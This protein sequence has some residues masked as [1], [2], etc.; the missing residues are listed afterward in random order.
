MEWSVCAYGPKFPLSD[1]EP[2]LNLNKRDEQEDGV[3]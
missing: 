3:Q 1:A 2:T